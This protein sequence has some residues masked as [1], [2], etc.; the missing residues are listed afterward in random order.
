MNRS[1]SPLELEALTKL[2]FRAPAKI[3]MSGAI[4]LHRMV[5]SRSTLLMVRWWTQV[6]GGG[7][8]MREAVDDN[9]ET[10]ASGRP[11]GVA[12]DAGPQ[13]TPKGS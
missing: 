9:G 11:G 1:R 12:E 8:V 10:I 3:G 7:Q 13:V 4:E 6:E 2:A 5:Q